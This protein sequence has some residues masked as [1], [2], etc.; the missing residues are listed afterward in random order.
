MGQHASPGPVIPPRISVRT[1]EKR[2]KSLPVSTSASAAHRGI[3]SGVNDQPA[4]TEIISSLISSL[5]AIS[6]P[7][8]QHFDSLP[9]LDGSHSTPVSPQAWRTEYHF[10]LF[11]KHGHAYKRDSS[12]P[13]RAG[14][15]MDTGLLRHTLHESSILAPDVGESIRNKQATALSLPSQ[16]LRNPRT[17]PR[18]GFEAADDDT[19]SIGRISIEPGFGNSTTSVA[20]VSSGKL[21]GARSYKDLKFSLSHD[22]ILGGRGRRWI[23]DGETDDEFSNLAGK[24]RVRLS[25]SSV[26]SD[27]SS[28]LSNK[29]S[30][31][32]IPKR[33]S[34]ARHSIAVTETDTPVLE[35]SGSPATV[36]NGRLVPTR[37]SSIRHSFN[38]SPAQR[39]RR[40]HRSGQTS[41][42]G[43][44]RSSI[45]S[46]P[47]FPERELAQVM[48][49]L[50]EEDDVTRRIRE[51]Q[52]QKRIRDHELSVANSELRPLSRSPSLSPQA[53]DQSL[54]LSHD[55]NSPETPWSLSAAE[56][57]EPNAQTSAPSPTIA[58]RVDR[59]SESRINAM[60]LNPKNA[61]LG[62]RSAELL[63]AQSSPPRRSNSRLLRRLSRPLSPAT[64]DKHRRTFS[65]GLSHPQTPVEERQQSLDL[66][67]ES[68]QEFLTAPRLSQRVKDPQTGRVISF[69]E[70]GDPAGSV[71]FCCVGMGLTRYIT[72]F[73]DELALTLRLRLITPDRPGVGASDAHIGGLDT[74]LGWPDD[75]RAIC[76]HLN[77]TKF[78]ILA[79]SA[80]AIYALATALRIPQ[81]IRGRIH[82]LAPWIP[83]SQLSTTS[84][85]QEAQPATALPYSQRFLRSLPA[86]F[87]KAANSSWLSATSASVTSKSPRRSKWRSRDPD[88]SDDSERSRGRSSSPLVESE[89]D[90]S[91]FS[92]SVTKDKE[93]TLPESS[94]LRPTLP[95][96]TSSR[97][98]EKERH[99]D[100]DTRLT[101]AIWDRATTGANPAVDLLVCLERHQ[102]IGFRYVDIKKAIVIHHGSKDARVPLENVKWLGKIM[103][104]CE[105]RVLDGEGHGLMASAA[106][107]GNILMEIS[108]EWDDWIRVTRGRGIPERRVTAAT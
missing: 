75:V 83:P 20:S 94:D 47:E 18:A 19:R 63:K 66:I 49:D 33:S 29:H 38:A 3:A 41:P 107:M 86:T 36:G 1:Q 60:A 45:D 100:Y 64:E 108:R 30:P 8:E 101:Q 70:V 14:F 55:G 15:G 80:G 74:P 72:A 67:D 37:D 24:P 92:A 10:P 57:I 17:R 59:N 51:L 31:I 93:I 99:G 97:L 52:D 58:Q 87:L 89:K 13:T 39:K 91:Q 62:K 85:Q 53:K 68:V 46:R 9:K 77:L 6:S 106:V 90:R 35:F 4:S 27:S 105:V 32:R 12:S 98:T 88:M 104:Q 16:E 7:A 79:H 11:S 42:Q 103:R 71:V 56:I 26:L 43:D 2:R 5:S 40:S 84:S 23:R 102:P 54:E 69:S 34:S 28:S 25:D 65:G 78:S 50:I 82:L 48:D 96:R 22:R 95:N 81:H 76:Q 44:A 61:S 21:R 73:Y